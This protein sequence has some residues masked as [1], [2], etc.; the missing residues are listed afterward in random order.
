[1]AAN[2]EPTSE[3][4]HV[5]VINPGSTSTKLARYLVSAG[6][7]RH[8]EVSELDSAS[9]PAP[10]PEA[11]DELAADLERRLGAVLEYAAA[12]P[13]PDCVA[14]R[15]GMVRPVPA[16]SYV[17]T[18]HMID[19]LLGCRFGRHASNL[20]APLAAAAA[21]R[22]RCPAIIADPVGVDEFEEVAR[23]SGWSGIERKSFSHALNLRA[24][25][26]RAAAA[27]D[28]PFDRARFIG[29]HLGGGVSVA[30]IDGGRIIDVNNSNEGGP[31]T[32]QRTG[33][34]PVLQLVDLCCSGEFAD[35]ESLK[36]RLTN[37]GGLVSY[38]GTSS[39][40][41]VLRRIDSGDE[42]AAF[43]LEAMIY[44]IAKEIGATAA[45]LRGRVD[46]IF[47]TGGFAR[48]RIVEELSKRVGWIAK[49]L[50]YPGEGE[51]VALAEAAARILLGVEE[52]KEY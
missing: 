19:D 25:A 11:D 5:I 10:K 12:G 50:V 32:P 16:G 42:R 29:A 47:L 36:R 7:E 37:E 13:C 28:L 34:L 24:C 18:Q 49:M 39:V 27:L 8:G 48:E 1:M 6:G 41:E 44:Q 30:A 15:G 31:F 20:G 4:Y 38:L 22:Y 46:A 9:I 21:E 40:E 51:M 23:L 2:S 45:V 3:K 14:A 35:A 26:R 17:V 52:A 33:S 43:V